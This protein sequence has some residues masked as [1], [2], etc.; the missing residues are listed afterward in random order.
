MNDGISK[1]RTGL[2]L[3]GFQEMAYGP[4]RPLKGVAATS[5][6]EIAVVAKR[7]PTREIAVEAI[8]ATLGRQLGLPI[9]EPILLFHDGAW[10][11]GSVLMNHPD[12]ARFIE[13]TESAVIDELSCWP[14][15]LQAACFDELIVNPDRHNENLLYD[16]NGFFLIDHGLCIPA[17]MSPTD[18][19]EDYHCN[20]LLD[21]KISNLKC[22]LDTQR[23]LRDARRWSGMVSEESI[24]SARDSMSGA[25]PD[26]ADKLTR[27]VRS[28]ITILS[29]ILEE[30]INPGPQ[31]RLDL[32]DEHNGA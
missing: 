23:A 21:L 14:P 24:S 31:G 18:Y 3:P 7:V 32:H 19:S 10:Y 22:E 30:R 8:C 16:G 13:T 6:G 5:D 17:G 11:F 20:R 2:L 25:D 28:R 29:G 26:I 15:L 1:I 12:L 27:F 4:T 9:P